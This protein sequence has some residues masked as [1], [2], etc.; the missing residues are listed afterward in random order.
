MKWTKIQ[1]P[2]E[3]GELF[4]LNDVGILLCRSPHSGDWVYGYNGKTYHLGN[5]LSE[6]EVKDIVE[7]QVCE[8]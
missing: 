6:R 2:V 7:K 4:C 8:S 1:T 3:N 5:D